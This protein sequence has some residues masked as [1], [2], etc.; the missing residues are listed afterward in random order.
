MT[1]KKSK[2]R[3]ESVK[4]DVQEKVLFINRC[5][6]VVKG[7]RR[8]SFSALVIV[9]DGNGR[10]GMGFGKANEVTDSIRKA[11][12]DATK[13]LV[14]VELEGPTI[15]HD[16]EATYGGARVL[17]KTAPGGTGVIAGSH[18]RAVL[19]MAGVKDVVAKNLR[20]N[21]PCN[22]VRATFKALAQLQN[23]KE[24]LEKRKQV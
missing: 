5:A 23:K 2:P 13:N 11:V 6:K 22:Q 4:S 3:E 19:E 8:F 16:V 10:V 15:P 20:G 1:D 7:G 24:V 18:V 14:A 12:G 17:I 21:N 9:G